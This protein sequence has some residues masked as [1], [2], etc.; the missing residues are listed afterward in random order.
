MRTVKRR[1][2]LA[3]ILLLMGTVM[4]IWPY[5]KDLMYE[6]TKTDTIRKYQR[7]L[8]KTNIDEQQKQARGHNLVL[9]EGG[10]ISE[11]QYG[12]TLNIYDGI[13]GILSIP[14]I[15]LELPIYHGVKENALA[16]GAGHM[17][18]SSLPIG[19]E[20][21][22][23]VLTGHTGFPGAEL[24][25]NISDLKIGDIFHLSVLC[26]TLSYRVDQ[27]KVVDPDNGEDLGAV[28]GKDYCTLVTCTPYG[29]N[30]HR[31]LVRGERTGKTEPSQ[32]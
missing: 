7:C 11:E 25:T 30:S 17:P 21:N 10:F 18:Q 1:I 28:A 27:I 14:S 8:A 5:V 12:I 23:T 9:H 22:H 20:G 32:G 6:Q 31:L 19:G 16:K 3:G 4:I 24:F 13:M 26:K 29:I 15:E 2:I